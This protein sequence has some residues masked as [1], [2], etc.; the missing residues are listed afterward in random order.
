MRLSIK[1]AFKNLLGSGLRVWLNV[2]IL[3]L[4]FVVMLFYNGMLEG[5]SRAGERDMI[6][7]EIGAA[8]Y[9]V[10][11]YDKLD[12][13]SFDNAHAKIPNSLQNERY[14][15]ILIREAS[16]YPQ[17]RMQGV[18]L[19][20]LPSQQNVFPDIP[21]KALSDPYSIVIGRRMSENLKLKKG[22]SVLIRWRDANGAFDALSF[23]LTEIFSTDNPPID[24]GHI[25]ID[26]HQL[27]RMSELQ[28][29]CTM[30]TL[31]QAPDEIEDIKGWIYHSKEDLLSDFYK[32]VNAERS[33]AMV[34]YFFLLIIGLLAI[35]DTQVLSVFRRTREIGTYIALGMTRRQV[36]QLF[37][38]EG[39]TY[40][41]LAVVMGALWGTPIFLMINKSGL[42]F[43]K[44]GADE[45]GY[46]MPQI[47]YPYYSPW[48]VILG[49]STLIA[50]SAI[51]SY[52]PSR[53]IAKLRPTDAIRGK[54]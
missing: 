50:T 12:P 21:T 9:W 33:G 51:V 39:T 1:L 25:Y 8:Q 41:L 43:G 4:A 13:F 35:F 54:R 53:K 46:A 52:I 44:M 40:S 15:P 42:D 17:G 36:V 29:E 38:V 6:R 18:I 10:E 47:V 11:S 27:Q 34:T 2:F 16:V 28:G 26:I 20:G 32:G 19:K 5:W 31:A 49:I 48:I 7:T 30:I 22:E 45:I 37:T 23:T 3:S 14:C 24:L